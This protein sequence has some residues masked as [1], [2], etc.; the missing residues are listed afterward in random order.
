MS[1]SEPPRRCRTLPSV[2]DSGLDAALDG[3]RSG[4]PDAFALLYRTLQPSVV[5]YLRVVA[6]QDADDVAAETWVSTTTWS[7]AGEGKG[8]PFTETW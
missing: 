4:D 2:E 7:S 6:G 5:R 8:S 3:A 1:A